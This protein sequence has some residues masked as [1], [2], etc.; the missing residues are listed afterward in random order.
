MRTSE[1]LFDFLARQEI[2]WNMNLSKSPWWGAINERI[3]KDIKT[4]LHKAF[5][6]SHLSYEQLEFIIECHL[7]NRPLAYIETE[8]G[9]DMVH[10]PNSILWGQNSKILDDTEADLDFVAKSQR[11][12]ENAR[13]HA[14][15]RW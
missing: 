5:A 9:E 1:S 10:T 13:K 14:W 11:R 7:N 4:T 12:L 2:K 15:T 6:R 3:I 8:M